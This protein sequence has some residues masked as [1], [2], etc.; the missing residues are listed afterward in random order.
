[1]ET[2]KSANRHPFRSATFNGH[3]TK[4]MMMVVV[5]GTAV[6]LLFLGNLSYFYG[7]FYHAVEKVHNFNVLMVDF[8]GGPIGQALADAYEEMKGSSF[9]TL[10]NESTEQYPTADS[11]VQAVRDGVY[12]ASIYTSSGASARLSA[13][14]SGQST[15]PYNATSAITYVWDE[16]RYAAL[17]DSLISG[18]LEAL[19]IAAQAGYNKANG[20]SALATLA[21]NNSIAV[22]AYLNPISCSEINLAPIL[23]VSRLLYNTVSMAMAVLQPF[24]F[25]MAVKTFMVM[26]DFYSKLT[27]RAGLTIVM[28]SSIVYTL[29][30][31]LVMTGYIWAFRED[32]N[33]QGKEFALTWMT[34]WLLIDIHF[35]VLHPFAVLLP[36][37]ALPFVVLTWILTNITSVVS[38]FEINSGFYRWGN[39]LPAYNAFTVLIDI[40][41]RGALPRLSHAL[42]IL[43]S[44]W[45]VGLAAVVIS[46]IR[47]CD[48]AARAALLAAVSD[49]SH[50]QSLQEDDTI[51]ASNGARD[52]MTDSPSHGRSLKEENTSD[53]ATN[54][55]RQEPQVPLRSSTELPT[56]LG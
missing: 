29:A 1:M 45:V 39:A 6:S 19:V 25:L 4:F 46:H 55:K 10:Y 34:L 14:L 36:I 37:P 20:M 31:A 56:P 50:Q 12:W 15:E 51:P 16:T 52:M 42:P 53:F 5:A 26:F 27:L 41:S 32:W 43:F 23:Q 3:R 17:S 21:Q 47:A 33:V 2:L 13:A 48:K 24:F 22:Q 38:P 9:P 7:S 18:S 40:W 30:A 44:W 11:M 28:V 49:S 8:D 35:C 54:E